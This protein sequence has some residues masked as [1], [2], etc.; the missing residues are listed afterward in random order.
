MKKLLIGIVAALI[1]VVGG[2][3]I[4]SLVSDKDVTETEYVQ[5]VNAEQENT[6]KNSENKMDTENTADD[7]TTQEQT[8]Q[9]SDEEKKVYT[10]TFMY[11]ISNSDEN[12]EETNKVIDELKKEYDGKVNFDIVNVDENP[13]AKE[14]F[15][16]DGQTPALIMLNTSN[17]ISAFEF[18][19][20]DKDKLKSAIDAAMK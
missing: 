10:P 1:V 5:E 19:C 18:K 7:N 17:D 6:E 8:Q 16:V 13:E 14:N 4:Y 9:S 3:V 2:V 12:F 15:P 20:G 11:F